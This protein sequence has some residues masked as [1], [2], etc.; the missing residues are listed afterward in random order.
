MEKNS[1]FKGRHKKF[2]KFKK[3][4]SEV[5]HFLDGL[6]KEY[7]TPINK[8]ECMD[9]LCNCKNTATGEDR[10]HYSMIKNVSEEGIE[11][12]RRFYNLIFLKVFFQ[13]NGEKQ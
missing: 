4:Q 8:R 5:L 6:K 7:N 12:L 11:Y 2:Q 3:K 10:V 13:E 1:S 9:A